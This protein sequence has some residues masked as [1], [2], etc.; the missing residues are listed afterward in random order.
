M[1]CNL[2]MSY[3]YK[4]NSVAQLQKKNS[5]KNLDELQS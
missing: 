1:P 3:V 5:R 4:P 2:C